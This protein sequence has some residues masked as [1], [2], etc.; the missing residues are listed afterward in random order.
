MKAGIA[1][2]KA[3][4]RF[5]RRSKPKKAQQDLRILLTLG[6]RLES[7]PRECWG[8]SIGDW[9]ITNLLY[10][11]D[12]QGRLVPLVPNRAQR[13]YSRTCRANNIV[14]KARQMGTT[15]WIAARFFV[16]TITRRGTLTVLV[17]HDQASA[18]QI[19][20]IVHRFWAN[21][22]EWLRNGALR[23]SRANVGQM[24]FSR[25]DSEY[26]VET[27][28]DPDAGRGLTIQ[29][30]HASEVARWPRDANATLASLR[31]AVPPRGEVVLESTARGAGGCFYEEWMAAH[32]TGYTR[33]FLPWWWE[34]AYVSAKVENATIEMSA[35]EI[36]LIKVHGL[37]AEQIL[38]RRKIWA[39]FRKLAAQEFAEDAESCFIAS[40]E[41]IFDLESIEQRLKECLAAEVPEQGSRMEKKLQRMI[42]PLAGRRYIVA[43]D[44]AGGGSEGDYACAQVI[45]LISGMQCAELQAHFAP[46]E[47]AR[48]VVKLAKEY[49]HALIA[50]ERNNHGLTVLAFLAT[51]E[52]YPHIYKQRGNEGVLTTRATRPEMIACIA[53]VL[54]EKPELFNSA[55]LLREL[56]TFVRHSDGRHA[57]ATGTHDDCVMAMGVALLARE[58]MAGSKSHA[59]GWGSLS[60]ESASSPSVL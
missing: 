38:Y 15:T 20:R 14:L 7:R 16:A 45:D 21:L 10:I 39:N 42:P 47:L 26:R 23:R 4:I 2:K 60:A 37:C 59:V 53:T 24:V 49:N 32:E 41:C 40:G 43:V 18:Q 44:S 30:L 46:E 22:P 34:E 48:E 31:A 25:L 27:A 54:S 6:N 9:L 33:H 12:K 28:A 13:E 55:R 29:N 51:K 58:E 36:D 1:G 57:A 35:E 52:K 8:Q 3:F 17:A 56:R 11:R 19:F 5:G 50:V